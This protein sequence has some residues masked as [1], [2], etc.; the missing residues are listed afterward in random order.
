MTNT[1]GL[2]LYELAVAYHIQ[3]N[4]PTGMMHFDPAEGKIFPPDPRGHCEPIPE[5][6]DRAKLYD[7]VMVFRNGN[8]LVDKL[9]SDGRVKEWDIDDPRPLTT[10]QQMF[11]FLDLEGSLDGVHIYE[12]LLRQRVRIGKV[13]EPE[14]ITLS[15]KLPRDFV[16]FHPRS[17]PDAERYLR[18]T[19]GTKTRLG[20]ALTQ[21]YPDIVGVQLKQSA[22]G[23]LGMGKVVEY[24][25]GG[26]GR[27]FFFKHIPLQSG[28]MGEMFIDPQHR[29]V[30]VERRY[31]SPQGQLVRI[32][33]R[34]V[35]PQEFPPVESYQ[36]GRVA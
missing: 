3:R 16:H 25:P 33:E 22:Y 27:E 28:D 7:G 1:N 12:A 9:V 29:I 19:V 32:A 5:G 18:L 13:Y 2:P 17:V 6:N 24:V 34:I 35:H 21:L 36:M 4:L 30:G 10:P 23:P 14:D 15:D 26:V 20:V 31:E 11:D 8:I